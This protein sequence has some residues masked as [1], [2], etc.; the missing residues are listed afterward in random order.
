MLKFW[1]WFCFLD[2]VVAGSGCCFVWSVQVQKNVRIATRQM[3]EIRNKNAR[4]AALKS[5]KKKDTEKLDEQVQ[6]IHMFY[7]VLCSI[8][9]NQLYDTQLKFTFFLQLLIQSTKLF[10]TQLN[11]ILHTADICQL[12]NELSSQYLSKLEVAILANWSRNKK[13]T[14]FIFSFTWFPHT[15]HI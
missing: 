13:F 7:A 11:Q 10:F 9:T 1:N 14:S 4:A 15:R 2:V 5:Q 12:I 3:K 8:L 6:D